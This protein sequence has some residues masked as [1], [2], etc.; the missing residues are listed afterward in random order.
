V[1]ASVPHFI[2]ETVGLLG[3]DEPRYA[4]VAREMLQR[5]DYVTPTL[6]GKPWLE[7]PP[8]YYWMADLAYKAAGGVHDWAAR[9]PSVALTILVVFFIYF[10]ARRFYRGMQLDAALITAACAIVIGFSRGASMDMP[11][12][13]TF[14]MAMLSWFAWYKERNRIWLLAF[15]FLLAL[16]LLAKGPV[17]VFLA[18]VILMLFIG[19][20]REWKLLLQTLW[21]AGIVL[22]LAVALPWY[23]AVQRANPDFFH[24]FIFQHNLER[25]TSDLYRHSQPFWYYI[26][27]VLLG[28]VPWI[29]FVIAAVVDAIR[30][31]RFSVEQPEGQ[32]DLRLFLTIWFLFPI[33]FFSFSRSKLPGYILPA[34]PAATILL[35]DLIRRRD[36]EGDKPPLWVIL[37]HAAI[38]AALLIAVFIV[39]FKLLHVPLPTTVWIVAGLLAAC[40][41]AFFT[42]TILSRGYRVLRF[43]TLVP[44]V[45]AF[46]MLLR[47]T[48][49]IVEALESA[50]PVQASLQL[51]ALGQLPTIAVYDVPRGIEYGLGFYRNHYIANY[52]RNEVPDTTHLV[53]AAAGTEKELEYRLPERRVTRIGG[54]EPQHLDFYLV[55]AKPPEQ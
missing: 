41:F 26:P 20:R 21:P 46:A 14:T 29:A 39:P 16:G 36:A 1:S 10:W 50:R 45:I 48:V 51:T 4:Q 6:W 35:A 47:G 9:V 5:H 54:W 43:A 32:E 7:K 44:V 11:L 22:F 30:D 40:T 31:W 37:I 3:A 23:I 18:A 27:V 38:S 53:V 19:L 12:T 13:A 8:M 33:V 42:V 15:Y 28:L 34:I 52:G 24:V 2:G 55:A 49:P 25:Y 17:A